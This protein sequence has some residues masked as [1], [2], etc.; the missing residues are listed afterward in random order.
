MAKQALLCWLN[1]TILFF[2]LLTTPFQ[3]VSQDENPFHADKEQILY[4][5]GNTVISFQSDFLKD[6]ASKIIPEFFTLPIDER[7]INSW[8]PNLKIKIFDILLI[9]TTSKHSFSTGGFIADT[10][11]AAKAIFNFKEIKFRLIT[12][13][14]VIQNWQKVS[15][16]K[17]NDSVSYL[18]NDT[19]NVGDRILL[20]F[21]N[22]S[23]DKILA[24][25]NFY[26]P[27]ISLFPFLASEVH[28][29]SSA[30]A[31]SSFIQKV[32]N[33]KQQGL[34]YI[35]QFYQYWP[36]EY[37][38]INSAT[39]YAYE[40]SKYALIFRR[41]G[42]NFPDSSLEYK[43]TDNNKTSSW[44]ET[45]HVIFLTK[46]E[47]NHKYVLQVRY[48]K[49]P[50]NVFTKRFHTRPK[51]YQ[52][53]KF[54]LF[55]IGSIALFALIIS[56]FIYEYRLRKQKEKQ[57][58][59]SLELKTVRSQLNPHF[60]FNSLSSIQSLINKNE[61]ENANNYL[62]GFANL[63]RTTL[64]SGDADNTSLTEELKTLENYLQLEQLRFHFKY[65]I[66][67]DDTINKNT[68]AIPSLVWLPLVEN[69][70]KHGIA[71]LK[72]KGII[73]I[74]FTRHENDLKVTI[75]DNSD[76]FIVPSS[77]DG[78]GLKLTKDRIKLLNR[79]F[80]ENIVSF[81]F[82]Q[83]QRTTASLTFKNWL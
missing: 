63:L 34:K 51:W 66:Y 81:E 59:I 47:P 7:K 21:M 20:E 3:A 52:T 13:G 83:G 18:F 30:A 14:Q 17:S 43:I 26:R 33:E 24:R 73:E 60:I 42:L 62:S 28:D 54:A 49:A 12:N 64:T 32:I 56:R 31:I 22:N 53:N 75:T 76:G 19:I 61:I 39:E 10:S 1:T 68:T 27:E 45:V 23:S 50:E 77:K 35:D 9:D 70:V 36:K 16:Q 48:R 4:R 2:R 37:G 15:E 29:T 65:N 11:S 67:A 71:S 74:K 80:K 78:Y 82:R 38:G 72:E 79:Q 41:P 46:F 69:A 58:R 57:E 40:N 25:F 5:F 8:G 6:S 44:H 55:I